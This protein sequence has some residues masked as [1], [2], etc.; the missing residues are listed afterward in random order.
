[1]SVVAK[2]I[3]LL[4][5]FSPQM[6]EIGLSQL[7]RLAGRD[8]ATTYRHLSALEALGFVEQNPVTKSYRI[9]PAV[10]PL[11]ELREATVPRRAGAM[12]P[13]KNLAQST[14]ETAHVAVLSGQVLHALAACESDVHSTRAVVD[15]KQFPLHATASGLCALAFGPDDLMG[16]ATKQLQAFTSQTATTPQEVESLVA[17]T[18][19]T[20]VS[21]SY[22]TFEADIHSLAVPA[23]DH[24]GQLAGT[25]AVACV[26]SRLTPNLEDEIRIGLIRASREITHNWGGKI[27]AFIETLWGRVPQAS[28]Q[29]DLAT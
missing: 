22:S 5:Y 23:F 20:G 13:L 3:E 25:V 10:L 27:P 8:K 29:K 18:W 9:G 15:M 28:Q 7:C 17:K 2:A 14:G 12:T 16:F 21:Q 26:A 4:G 19:Q 6:P 11:A 1:M 24:Y